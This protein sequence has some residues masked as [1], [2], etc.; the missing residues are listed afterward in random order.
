M[1][2]S[3]V[4]RRC[5]PSRVMEGGRVLPRRL[6]P[7]LSVHDRVGPLPVDVDVVGGRVEIPGAHSRWTAADLTELQSFGSEEPLHVRGT[8]AD[9]ERLI[10]ALAHLAQL[11]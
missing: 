4:G 7:H 5:G 10:D 1:T 9:T 2:R 3:R 8:R 11:L 6:A